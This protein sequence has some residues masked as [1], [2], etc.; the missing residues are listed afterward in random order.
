[1]YWIP[2]II[3][4]AIEP[5]FLKIQDFENLYTFLRGPL[6]DYVFFDEKMANSMDDPVDVEKLNRNEGL[7]TSFAPYSKGRLFIGPMRM[8]QK[9]MIGYKCKRSSSV[10]RYEHMFHNCHHVRWHDYEES[11]EVINADE[12]YGTWRPIERMSGR[13]TA[14]SEYYSGHF[15]EYFPDG[16][17]YQDFYPYDTTK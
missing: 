13:F 12:E 15:G 2:E 1:M 6:A 3:R 9:R 17:Y 5:E 4:S 16:G 7:K 14:W 11:K 8:L 10:E